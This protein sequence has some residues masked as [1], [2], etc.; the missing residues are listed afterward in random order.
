VFDFITDPINT[1]FTWLGYGLVFGAFITTL[2]V[3]GFMVVI[4]IAFKMLGVY[5]ARTIVIETAKVVKD[6]G[7]D[8]ITKNTHITT[9]QIKQMATTANS[10]IKTLK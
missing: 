7:I 3:I 1:L 5:F 4:P 9:E 10:K 6:L 2:L 8:K